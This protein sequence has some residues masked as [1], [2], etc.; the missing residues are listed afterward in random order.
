MTFYIELPADEFGNTS[1]P[2]CVFEASIDNDH[3][4]PLMTITAPPEMIKYAG[5]YADTYGG[6]AEV[7]GPAR[8]LSRDEWKSIIERLG[9]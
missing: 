2:R 5:M 9:K 7:P 4:R 8:M 3:G 6:V 1:M